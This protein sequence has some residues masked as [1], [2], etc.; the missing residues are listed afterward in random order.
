VSKS[1]GHHHVLERRRQRIFKYLAAEG[2]QS[3]ITLIIRPSADAV[4]IVRRL[5]QVTRSEH[6]ETERVADGR[7]T[8]LTDRVPVRNRQGT[9]IS[10]SRLPAISAIASARM[11]NRRLVASR[12]AARGGR[13]I[14]TE[15]RLWRPRPTSFARR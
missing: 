5:S 14:I 11:K 9:V 13:E 8:D 7:H 2:V 10:A 3:S 4:E 12:Q 15:G 1:E 6:F